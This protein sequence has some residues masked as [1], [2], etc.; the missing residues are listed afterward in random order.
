LSKS[1]GVSIRLKISDK[2]TQHSEETDQFEEQMEREQ[3]GD[4]AGHAY[5]ARKVGQPNQDR[6]ICLSLWIQMRN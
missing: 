3:D 5:H 6:S 4:E 1:I 2:D